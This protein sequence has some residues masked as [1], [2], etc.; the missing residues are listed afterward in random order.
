MKFIVAC[1]VLLAVLP[2]LAQPVSADL[3]V[4]ALSRC[5]SEFFTALG[6]RKAALQELAPITERGSNAVF[7]VPDRSHPT[8]SRIL[9]SKP[10]SVQGLKFVGFFD[11]VVDIPNGMTSYSWGYLVAETVS[12]TE[13]ALKP[14]LWDVPRLRRDGPVFVRSEVWSHDN[15]V[16]NWVK[17]E[18]ESGVPKRG[19]VE[20]VFL[21]EPYDGET[22]FIRVGCSIQ[23]NVTEPLLRDL[24]PDLRP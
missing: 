21:I 24:R 4:P 7:A 22:A 2:V 16:P 10:A 17:T 6:T 8:K 23:G 12:A 3:A 5:G 9:F 15:P 19:T 13:A 11:E 14:L 18:T 20:R 1:A